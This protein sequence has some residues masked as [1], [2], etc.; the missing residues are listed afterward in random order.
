MQVRH[1]FPYLGHSGILKATMGVRFRNPPLVE[2]WHAAAPAARSYAGRALRARKAGLISAG[3][4]AALGFPNLERGWKT[5][6]ERWRQYR[7][8]KQRQEEGR[9]LKQRRHELAP[10]YESQAFVVPPK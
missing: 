10:F 8:N 2:L 5:T 1:A 9:A 6:R 7:L 3:Q 4:Q